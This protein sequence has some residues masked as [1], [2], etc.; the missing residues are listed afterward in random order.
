MPY[1]NGSTELTG[2]AAVGWGV[3]GHNGSWLYGDGSACGA[4][5]AY[6]FAWERCHFDVCSP[7]AGAIGRVYK[8]RSVDVGSRLRAV[9]T[10]TKYDCN[11]HGSTAAGCHELQHRR[12]RKS[13]RSR[14]AR[15]SRS[16][17]NGPAGS[18][19]SFPAGRAPRER[20]GRAVGGRFVA[21]DNGLG[22]DGRQTLARRWRRECSSPL[23]G[24]LLH[25]VGASVNRHSDER[26]V[27]VCQTLVK[28]RENVTDRER[29]A[30]HIDVPTRARPLDSGAPLGECLGDTGR[31]YF[32]LYVNDER[33]RP[34]ADLI[35]GGSRH[36]SRADSENYLSRNPSDLITVSRRT[37]TLEKGV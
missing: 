5:C 1:N 37:G 15:Q 23:R 35:F 21:A 16:R 24:C 30:F 19:Q 9:V 10:A 18:T 33:E 34:H 12:R 28:G 3:V 31:V 4:E 7:I 25:R 11:A 27:V 6:A 20:P 13:F 14:K 29:P 26:D 22:P 32:T 17:R 2:R 36:Q 8:V